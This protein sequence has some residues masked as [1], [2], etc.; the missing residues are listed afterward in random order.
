M[1]RAG[2]V[3]VYV[4]EGDIRKCNEGVAIAA[5]QPSL[6]PGHPHCARRL[7]PLTTG[8]VEEQEAAQ[9]PQSASAKIAELAAQSAA[10]QLEAHR[11]VHIRP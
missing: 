8:L 10:G 7:L 9:A 4:V 2:H 5:L 6:Q 3:D 11:A 1:Q